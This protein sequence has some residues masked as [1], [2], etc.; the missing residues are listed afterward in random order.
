MQPTALLASIALMAAATS[1]PV[2]AGDHQHH[3][4]HD[5]QPVADNRTTNG[6]NHGMQAVTHSAISDEPGYGWCYFTDPAASR[7]LVIGPQSDYYYSFG[8]GLRWIASAQR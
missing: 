4:K 3:R 2:L 1:L 5:R 6:N 7:A 8:T